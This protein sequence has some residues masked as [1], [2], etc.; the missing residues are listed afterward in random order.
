MLNSLPNNKILDQSNVKDLADNK[1]NI[2]YEMNFVLGRLEN[3]LG[4]GENAGYQ[5][6]L[7]FQKCFQNASLSGSLKV[8]IVW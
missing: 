7:L 4:K 6:F 2:T 1:L 8:R 5:N 3:I